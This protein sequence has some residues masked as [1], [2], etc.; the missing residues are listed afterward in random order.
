MPSFLA[1]LSHWSHRGFA[2][3]R[4]LV[5]LTLCAAVTLAACQS[6]QP[7][8]VTPTGAAPAETATPTA[9][10]VLEPAPLTE[11]LFQVQTP[12]E[13]D[14]GEEIRIEFLDE[15]T[16]LA[17]NPAYAQMESKDR[18]NFAA[19]VPVPLGSVL[20]YRYVRT[21]NPLSIEYSSQGS[22]VRY[23]LYVV[24]GPGSIRD[25]IAAWKSEPAKSNLGR[26]RG[27]V[28]LK[29]GQAPA[30]NALITA[31]GMSTLTS[32]D[33]SFLLEGLPEGVHNMVVYSLDGSFRPF[34]QGASVA[35]DST[36]PAAVEVEPTEKVTVTFVVRPPEENLK[37]APIR[38]VGNIYSLGNTFADLRG[39]VSVLASRAP[40][41]SLQT[42][43]SYSI[44]LEL[45]VGLDLRYKY[46][47]GDGFWN[48]ERRANG[49]LR[50]RQFI[51]PDEDVTIEDTIDT[52]TTEGYEPVSFTVTVPENT[53]VTDSIS[54]QFNPYGWTEPIPMWT[55]GNNRW[56]Y[57]LYN[58]LDLFSNASYRYCRNE[59]CG[60][61]DAVDTSGP[62]AAGHPF[63]PSDQTQN[64]EDTVTEWNW[65][66]P[67]TSS[68]V[69][70]STGDTQPR[71][72]FLAGVEW[73]PLYHPSWQPYFRAAVQNMTDIGA[74]SVILTPTW[75]LT[76]QI[77]PVIEPVPGQDPLWLDMTGV[78]KTAEEQGLT[79]ILHPML[80]YNQDPQ[81]WW[82]EARRDDGWWQ[83][84]FDQYRAFLLYHADLAEQVKAKTLILGDETLLP[85]VPFG[86]MPDG[87]PSGVPVDA[88]RRWK[89]L[90]A[91][92]RARYQGQVAWMVPFQGKLATVPLFIGDLDLAYVQVSAPLTDRD[93]ATPEQLQ[94]TFAAALADEINRLRNRVKGPVLIGL[95][96]PAVQ[97]YYDGCITSPNGCVPGSI[98]DTPGAVDPA[99]VHD[100]QEQAE[101]FNAL[102]AAASSVD[103]VNGFFAVGYYPPVELRDLSTSVRGKPAGDMLWYWFPHLLGEDNR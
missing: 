7:V 70:V 60:I 77:P 16:G 32:S 1:F 73:T 68:P 22:Q 13:L 9:K 53:P 99:A 11:I 19:L 33:G 52:W 82:Q 84:W 92:V 74:N 48:A 61:A 75:K 78:A 12:S 17:L 85:A 103:W 91:E 41:L 40:V 76:H 36:T 101:A 62:K 44:T 24:E 37:G 30:V 95:K 34:Q 31:G 66:A 20:R 6:L 97:G 26:V 47:L 96:Y 5:V 38:L 35:N 67:S 71:V 83:S 42:D 23:R 14:E 69:V 94:E 56:F 86:T 57:V 100:Y 89:D 55:L 2:G 63:K 46:T 80:R 43:G 72:N 50:L 54:I 27:Q 8:V 64:F 102:L 93:A 28:L 90:I 29:T 10:P 79:L 98:F 3:L 15:V 39:G 49:A 65:L 4:V 25:M 58:P 87:S 81:A 88:E 51:V 21:G 45:P 18:R 59:Q